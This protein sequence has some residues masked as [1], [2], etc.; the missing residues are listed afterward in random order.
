M[1][2]NNNNVWMVEEACCVRLLL[3]FLLMKFEEQ[4]WWWDRLWLEKRLVWEK[5]WFLCPVLYIQ[6]LWV[7]YV[8]PFRSFQLARNIHSTNWVHQWIICIF[9]VMIRMLFHNKLY[10]L[11]RCINEIVLPNHRWIILQYLC[12]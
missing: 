6:G 9:L 3:S 8:S 10:D 7:E 12:I 5:W 11:N 2:H 4:L 1:L